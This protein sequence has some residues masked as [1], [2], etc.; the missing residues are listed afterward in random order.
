MSRNH[1]AAL[2]IAYVVL[3]ILVVFN[4]VFGALILA[5]LV[6]TIFNEPLAIR[7]LGASG[8][9]GPRGSSWR[10]EQ[11]WFLASPPYFSITGC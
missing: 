3:R 11:S 4:W 5:L 8:F 2:P 1:S 6:F 7:A 9:A 10:C